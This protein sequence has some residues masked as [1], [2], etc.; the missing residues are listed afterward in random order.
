[1]TPAE[2]RA[3]EARNEAARVPSELARIAKALEAIVALLQKD[4][5]SQ[6]GTCMFCNRPGRLTEHMTAD[7]GRTYRCPIHW[8]TNR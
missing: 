1:M 7:G 5:V 8:E 2:R 3:V 6:L 4:G